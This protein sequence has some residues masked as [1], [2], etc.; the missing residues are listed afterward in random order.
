MP[1]EVIVK[2][3]ILLAIG[4]VLICVG[5]SVISC[6]PEGKLSSSDLPRYTE[7]QITTIALDYLRTTRDKETLRCEILKSYDIEY[8]SRASYEGNGIWEVEVSRKWWVKYD[9]NGNKM[10]YHIAPATTVLIFDEK[11]GAIH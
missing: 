4:I 5:L 11:T 3:K 7:A 2:L 10:V 1:K 8:S 9:W 6:Q